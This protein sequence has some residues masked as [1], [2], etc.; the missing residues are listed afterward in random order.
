[1]EIITSASGQTKD[2][3]G[4]T[5]FDFVMAGGK[6]V[7][8][9][10]DSGFVELIK[11]VIF[12]GLGLPRTSFVQLIR[13]EDLF[14]LLHQDIQARYVICLDRSA[15]EA[16]LAQVMESITRVSPASR[17]IV[18]TKE[19]DQFTTALLIE[20]GAHN[21]I[22]KPISVASFSEKLAFTIAPQGR[23]SKLI[24]KGKKQLDAG[25]WG[26]ALVTADEILRQK[27]DS[28][29]GFM[30]RGDAYKGLDMLTQAEEMYRKA[31]ESSELYLAPLKR[32][33]TLYEQAGD[34]E[35]QLQYLRRMNEISPLDK[36]RI[37][38]IGEIEIDRGNSAMAEEMFEQVIKIAKHEAA[39]MLSNISSR[40]ASICA[41]RDPE[42]AIRYSKRALDLRGGNLTVSDLATVNILG[43]SLRKQGKWREAIAEY[44][45][46]LSVL[47]DN[48][49][50]LYNMALAYNEGRETAKAL[51]MI[52]KTLEMDPALPDSGKNVAFNIGTIFQR[53]GRNGTAY[54]KK[55]YEQDPNDKFLWD[56]YKRSQ[57][58]QRD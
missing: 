57:A 14:D 36:Q 24:D 40:I 39:D 5:I 48:A 45:R 20:Q 31:A 49:G 37:L 50:L 54:F 11:S 51:A 28:A 44:H 33:A 43:I 25:S 35:K 46:V 23:L 53:A 56:A 21:I 2:S 9:T 29:A 27:P 55:A 8:L 58:E 4:A 32:L 42:M 7:S 12:R 6:F 18:L 15:A 41:N 30:I 26:E 16:T 10:Q 19:V 17:I 13:L 22:T 38:N 52:Q 3:F 1:M 34:P 47:P